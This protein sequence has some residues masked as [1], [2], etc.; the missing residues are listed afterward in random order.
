MSESKVASTSTTTT[1]TT[2]TSRKETTTP[3]GGLN[4][5]HLVRETTNEVMKTATHV[6]INPL[7]VITLASSLIAAG[8]IGSSSS[9][10]S[11]DEGGWHYD[12]DVSSSGPMTCQYV[13]VVDTLN[14]CFWPSPGEW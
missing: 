11:W 7:E 8:R 12:Q 2:A 13:L 1:T 6:T 3:G 14:F 4:L 5:L 9:G 10:V